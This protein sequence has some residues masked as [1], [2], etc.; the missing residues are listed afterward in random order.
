MSLW[1]GDSQ[2]S[3]ETGT[4]TWSDGVNRR[5]G[6][7][8]TTFGDNQPVSSG[9]G[10]GWNGTEGQGSVGLGLGADEEQRHLG[11]RT[12]WSANAEMRS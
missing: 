9:A 12:S 11:K 2:R 4:E 3:R 7:D 1:R 6:V 5:E 10:E 8:E